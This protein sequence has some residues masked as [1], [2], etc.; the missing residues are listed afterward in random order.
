MLSLLCTCLPALV[1]LLDW[2]TPSQLLYRRSEC[3][4]S[5]A[6]PKQEVYTLLRYM[7]RERERETALAL[8]PPKTRQK[9][10]HQIFSSISIY[11]TAMCTVLLYPSSSSLCPVGI[12]DNVR[13]SWLA[14][15]IEAGWLKNS[16]SLSLNWDGARKQLVNGSETFSLLLLLLRL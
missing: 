7:Q 4:L 3:S 11:S 2:V 10:T 9:S 12:I 1:L 15:F 16:L 13:V 5:Q 6:L 8:E 14:G